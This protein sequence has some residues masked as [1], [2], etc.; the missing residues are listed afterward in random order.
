MK[1]AMQISI[2]SEQLIQACNT[3]KVAVQCMT[4][5]ESGNYEMNTHEE[6]LLDSLTHAQMLILDMT[7][8]I[9]ESEIKTDSVFFAGELD[10]KK[11]DTEDE[12]EEKIAEIE[13]EI[14]EE[15]AGVDA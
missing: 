13:G 15:E 12:L 11:P 10:D 7:R 9:S 14:V 1:N 5:L 2:A 4:G 6:I 8:F 3:I